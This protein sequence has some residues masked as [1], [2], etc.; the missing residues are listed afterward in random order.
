[1]SLVT[2][3]LHKHRTNFAIPHRL[4]IENLIIM[5]YPYTISVAQTAHAPASAKLPHIPKWHHTKTHFYYFAQRTNRLRIFQLLYMQ[6]YVLMAHQDS[7]FESGGVVS[8]P[9]CNAEWDA[10]IRRS[11]L[12][13]QWPTCCWVFWKAGLFESHLW[14]SNM[15]TNVKRRNAAISRCVCTL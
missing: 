4:K 3:G 12:P 7:K 8:P 6:V 5:N 13:N 2:R 15:R 11:A 9:Q 1:M 10:E 14:S